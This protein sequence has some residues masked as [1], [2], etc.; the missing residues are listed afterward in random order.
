MTLLFFEGDVWL[1]VDHWKQVYPPLFNLVSEALN[2]YEPNPIHPS[3]ITSSLNPSSACS[4]GTTSS[5]QDHMESLVLLD[6]R[7]RLD[8]ITILEKDGGPWRLGTGA[9]GNV[10]SLVSSLHKTT[11]ER[12]P[13]ANGREDGECTE[14]CYS[15]LLLP[16]GF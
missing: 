10:S 1:A 12:I 2:S 13:E 15:Y 14:T 5:L 16:F 7:L 8:Q 3:S 4:A 9:F 11:L 6:W